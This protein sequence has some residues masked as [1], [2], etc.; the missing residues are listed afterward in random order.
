MNRFDAWL[1]GSSRW[2][3]IVA[4]VVVMA[5]LGG[6]AFWGYTVFNQAGAEGI[7]YRWV[8]V[9]IEQPPYEDVDDIVVNRH[10]GLPEI[11]SP[12]P[13]TMVPGL[14]IFKQVVVGDHI[15]GS[16]VYVDATTGEVVHQDVRPEDREEFDAVLA[17]LRFEGSDPPDIWPYSG[18]PPSGPPQRVGNITYI[19]PDPASGIAFTYVLSDG[20]QGS[21]ISLIISNGWSKRYVDAQTGEVI[22]EDS[23]RVLDQVDER[24]REAF[25]RLTSSIELVAQ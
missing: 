24:D 25:D 8:N 9:S 7:R 5:A 1:L 15:E 17:T 3:L 20:P 22:V 14:R 2:K 16:D 21:A 18:T 19:K 12:S 23:E 13:D 6:A 11:Y 4:A 10:E